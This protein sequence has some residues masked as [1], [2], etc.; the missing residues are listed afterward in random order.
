MKRGALALLALAFGVAHAGGPVDAVHEELIQRDRQSA[1]LAHPE[2]RAP[3]AARD[4]AHLQARRDERQVQARE[5]EAFLLGE[6]LPAAPSPDYRPLPLPGR[7]RHGVDPV[8]P[9]SVGR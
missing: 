1:E 4:H 3:D 9:A 8:A 7:P 2:L 5:R 6:P